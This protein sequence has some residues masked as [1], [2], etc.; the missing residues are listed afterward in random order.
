MRDYDVIR[1]AARL[2]TK[3]QLEKS[4]YDYKMQSRPER[5]RFLVLWIRNRLGAI[6]L[7]TVFLVVSMG[8]LAI[9]G[10]WLERKPF[11]TLV[12]Y[13]PLFWFVFWLFHANEKL[14][15]LMTRWQGE[16]KEQRDIW[17]TRKDA[18]M[19]MRGHLKQKQV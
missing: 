16:E 13:I 6:T 17:E 1:V 3:E 9:V 18:L 10:D 2:M 19:D 11:I 7:V 14:N 8:P 4:I 15:E 12:L 5:R